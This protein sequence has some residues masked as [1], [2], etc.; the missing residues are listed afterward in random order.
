MTG[1]GEDPDST[2]RSIYFEAAAMPRVVAT[3]ALKRLWPGAVYGPLAPTRYRAVDLGAELPGPRWIRVTNRVCGICASDLHLVHVDVDPMVHPAA[4]PGFARIY[5]GHEVVSEVVET[6]PGVEGLAPGDR[7]VMKSRFLGPTCHS[8]EIEPVCPHCARGD[9]ALCVNQSAGVGPR[10][11]GG[12]WSDGYTAHESEVWKLP[13]DLDDDAGALLEPLAC[14][15]RAVLRRPPEPGERALVLGCGTIGLGTVQALRA[16]APEAGVWARAR[17]PQQ[18]GRADAD[19]ATLL[20]GDFLEEAAAVTGASLY[21]GDFGNRTLVG[22]F[23]VVYD[24]V[25]NA[26]TIQQAL[27]ITRA[28]GTVVVVGVHLHRVK[29]DL[30]PVWHQE[31]DLIGTYAHGAEHW[32][33][34]ELSTFALT[35]ELMAEDRLDPAGLITHRFGLD[36]WREAIE[37]ATDKSTGSIKVVFD[38]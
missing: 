1:G 37:T 10:G 25:G 16:L 3:L 27:R 19:G 33:G 23:D 36:R 4:L 12:G 11:V 24:C 8:Q 26:E 9:Y 29:V 35:A 34:R 28:G 18:R 22:G 30:T 17:H 6:G 32:G 15:V 38:L 20:D 5:L 21:R 31:I 2:V 13:R 7:V 14:G